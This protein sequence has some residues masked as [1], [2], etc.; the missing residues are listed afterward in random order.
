M[1]DDL[2]I[3]GLCGAM[4]KDTFV[5]ERA[6]ARGGFGIVYRGRHLSL[7]KQIAVKVFAPLAATET[8]IAREAI[9]HFFQEIEI[10]STLEH[11]AI[12]RPY[13]CGSIALPG[14]GEVPWV[15]LE[16]LEGPTLAGLLRQQP[17]R[18]WSPPEALQLLR[19]VLEA[20]A[21][22]HTRGIAHRDVAPNN[23]IVCDAPQ[24][25]RVRLIDFGIARIRAP[26]EAQAQPTDEPTQS[27]L[28]AHSPRYPAPEQMLRQHTG[29]WTD[30]HAIG[31]VLHHMLTGEL[32]YPDSA[33]DPDRGACALRRPTPGLV[34]VD[35]GAWEPVLARAVAI[36]PRDRYLNARELLDALERTLEA[37]V[38]GQDEFGAALPEN[39][40]AVD[41]APTPVPLQLN[42][43]E[44]TVVLYPYAIAADDLRHG[45][46]IPL[47]A[48]LA[49]NL[50]LHRYA[51]VALALS[52]VGQI[53]ERPGLYSSE[54]G[55]GSRLTRVLL[56]PGGVRHVW[57]GRREFGL[58][59]VVCHAA[60]GDGRSERRA[61]D[62][63]RVSLKVRFAAPTR[64]FVI[65]EIDEPDL[66][67]AHL[68]CIGIT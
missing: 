46:E 58:R 7:G 17:R 16:W 48:G 23:I 19:P 40:R 24:G 28:V 47:G 6:V 52:V 15:A 39:W 9:Q 32:P 67:R 50:V 22:A 5:L 62:V 56:E 38:P 64:D 68:A 3:L 36:Y 12:V 33:H 14:R 30:V 59:E 66:S 42:T 2:D 25:P 29:T 44:H 54:S 11:P 34:D 57:C 55:V 21:E 51:D 13:D 53:G 10:L 61:I 35:V 65:L 31:L 1:K 8:A 45:L 43:P 41:V 20:L 37:A 49:C 26:F 63:G 18:T 60:R 27:G 4:L